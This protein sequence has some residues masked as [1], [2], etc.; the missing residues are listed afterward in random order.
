MRGRRIASPPPSYTSH[1][2]PPGESG[3]IGGDPYEQR[4]RRI[5]CPLCA[6]GVPLAEETLLGRRGHESNA[7]GGWV[8]AV[9]CGYEDG[10]T[11][12][13]GMATVSMSGP[14]LAAE[15]RA[16]RES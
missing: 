14:D 2:G 12:H 8:G 6:R 4:A 7:S 11:M 15:L 3:D 13:I 9:A 1:A 16:G 10:A 5:L